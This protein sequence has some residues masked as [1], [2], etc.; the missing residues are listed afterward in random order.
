MIQCPRC[1]GS[2]RCVEC[3]G[4]GSVS[5]ALCHGKGAVRQQA[6]SG[7]GYLEAKCAMCMGK[8]R[9]KCDPECEVCGGTGTLEPKTE[10][11][12]H[13][14]KYTV[15]RSLTDQNRTPVVTYVILGIIIVCAFLSGILTGRPNIFFGLGLLY[16][17]AVADG[18][19]WRIITSIFLH[20]NWSHLLVN[21]WS[22]YVLC[23]MMETIIGTK[24]FLAL[25]F[26][27]GV[28]GNLLSLLFLF[29]T[30]SVG[31]SGALFGVMA[32]YLGL[33]IRQK[34]FPQSVINN[35]LIIFGVNM[36]F[37]FMVPNI[38]IWA[39]LG[40]ALGGFLY[41]ATIRLS[42]VEKK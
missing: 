38:N 8:G 26:I 13:S 25:F 2:G 18:Q 9:L 1:G 12:R 19:L 42:S 34:I 33:N 4:A 6:P 41:A 5:C 22:L 11:A 31:A 35:M 37:G 39:H 27:A 40:G 17:P 36:A 29:G 20:A 30:P 23:P 3:G 14:A 21:G 10:L 16:G 28:I 15:S 32:A 7:D 24:R